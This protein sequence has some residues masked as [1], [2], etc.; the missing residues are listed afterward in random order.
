[1]GLLLEMIKCCFITCD[2]KYIHYISNKGKSEEME[3]VLLFNNTE[4]AMI[5]FFSAF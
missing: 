3:E 4:K 5:K 1:M 2:S